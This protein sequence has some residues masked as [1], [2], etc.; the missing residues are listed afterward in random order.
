MQVSRIDAGRVSIEPQALQLED[1]LSGLLE[2]FRSKW[3]GRE[4]VVTHGRDGIPAVFADPHKLEEILINLI[5]NAVKY[6]ANG[7][8]VE[9]LIGT[10]PGE[11]K[12]SVRDHGDGIPPEEIP[13]L[14]QKFA[15]ISSPST[16]EIP[17]TGLGLYI[18]KG[19]VEAHGGRVWVDS[20]IGEGST[21]SFTLPMAETRE[22]AAAV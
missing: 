4:I 10:D 9:V 8:P 18:V 7:S 5:D 15:R 11:V 13:N 12:V 17:G 6:S 20:V 22:A 21:F 2:Q 16:A 3:V 14:F 19:F 1:T